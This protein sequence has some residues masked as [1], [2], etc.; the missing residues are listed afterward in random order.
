MLKP[1]LIAIAFVGALSTPALALPFWAEKIA[2]SHCEYLSIGLDWRTALSQSFKDNE[3]WR[4][5]MPTDSS[6]LSRIVMSAIDQ[7]CRY[8]EQKA[9]VKF[10]QQ[11]HE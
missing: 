11:S 9:F 3:H 7:E 4:N 5:E 2:R 1:S 10:Q 8:L 6:I